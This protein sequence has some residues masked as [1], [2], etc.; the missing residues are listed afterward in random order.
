M[1]ILKIFKLE[2]IKRKL[3]DEN[4]RYMLSIKHGYKTKHQLEILQQY[5][6]CNK[7][8][9]IRYIIDNSYKNLKNEL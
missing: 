5:Y 3:L 7:S 9:L 4:K 2:V 1:I 6:K 8:Q